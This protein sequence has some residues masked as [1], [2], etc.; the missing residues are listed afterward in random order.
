MKLSEFAS[1]RQK[2]IRLKTDVISL[3][4][5]ELGNPQL[6]NK[7]I[8][9]TGTNGK[10]SV[11]A[12]T[13]A[14][15]RSSG[16][17][18]CRFNS[19]HLI[20]PSDSLLYN[21]KQISKEELSGLFKGIEPAAK[22]VEK[23]CGR[24]PSQFEILASAAFLYFKKKKP[25][26]VIIEVGMGGEGDATNVIPS[27]LAAV[28]T[29]I[30]CDHTAFLGASVS[31]IARK[32]SAIIKKGCKVIS[33]VQPK[34]AEIILRKKAEECRAEFISAFPFKSAGFEEIYEK[35]RLGNDEVTLSLGGIAQTENASVAVEI[36]RLFG[37]SD[38]HIAEGLQNAKHPAR[39]EKCGENLYFDGAHNIAGATALRSSLDRYFPKERLNFI[40]GTMKDK[41]Y[42]GM[43]EILSR[44]DSVFTFVPFKDNERAALPEE[45]LKAAA[46]LGIKAE[47][48]ELEAALRERSGITVVCG[49]LY[50]YKDFAEA[51]RQ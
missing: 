46:S 26:T 23:I 35:I 14:I 16:L 48:R 19:P 2:E 28:I 40:M 25:D 29:P 12:F 17:S 5:D 6:S 11:S 43:I 51:I 49:S 3:L 27:P 21:G 4:L 7:Y 38:R 45:L 42:K 34:E 44:K 39:F 30:S 47:I 15:L 22:R 13:D 9:I 33:A 37:I 10:G 36:A 41:E 32:K 50:L 20:T 8:H 18:V 1:T 31:E 24:H